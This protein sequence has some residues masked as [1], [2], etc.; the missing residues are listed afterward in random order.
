MR[1]KVNRDGGHFAKQI[2]AANTSGVDASVRDSRLLRFLRTVMIAAVL[3][4]VASSLCVAVDVIHQNIHRCIMATIIMIQ[5]LA[6]LI[7][8]HTVRP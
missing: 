8:I 5:S 7:S 6:I 1:N 2:D 3:F 4:S